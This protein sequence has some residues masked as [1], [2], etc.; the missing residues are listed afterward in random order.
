MTAF[1]SQNMNDKDLALVKEFMTD[2]NLDLS[3]TRAFKSNDS[4]KF[5]ISVGSID[6]SEK[7]YKFKDADF[8]VQYGEFSSYLSEV[9]FNLAKAI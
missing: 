2:K 1:F 4:K 6:K 3:N 8:V 9:N 5:I 7:E